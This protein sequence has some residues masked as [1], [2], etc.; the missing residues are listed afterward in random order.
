M[1]RTTEGNYV[2]ATFAKSESSIRK[3]LSEIFMIPLALERRN[4]RAL[5]VG[6]MRDR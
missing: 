1:R 4:D 2:L 6:Q 3:I 5:M